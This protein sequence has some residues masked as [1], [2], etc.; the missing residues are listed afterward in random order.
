MEADRLAGDKYFISIAQDE[1]GQDGIGISRTEINQEIAN[2]VQFIPVKDA[3]NI[4]RMLR[5]YA[6]VYGNLAGNVPLD[7]LTPRGKAI[8]ACKKYP[9][10]IAIKFAEAAG[11][12]PVEVFAQAGVAINPDGPTG[13][14]VMD[15]DTLERR[16][17]EITYTRVVLEI[18]GQDAID[19]MTPEAIK[20][21]AAEIGWPLIRV[22]MTQKP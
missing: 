1:I 5:V 17:A 19:K 18:T 12:N 8:V 22:R 7:D 10:G 14:E 3:S 9:G 2:F 4:A 16:L 6:E 13:V 11:I 15:W 20:A 21:A